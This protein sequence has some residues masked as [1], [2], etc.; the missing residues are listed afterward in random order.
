M[1]IKNKRG[2]TLVA[3]VITIVILLILAGIIITQLTERGL[4]EKTEEA[5]ERSINA[6]EKE[7]KTLEEYSDRINEIVGSRE[8]I[9]VDKSEYEE[10]KNDIEE[11]KK[12]TKEEKYS[13]TENV[14]G[15]WIDGKKIYRKVL[16][17]FSVT[18]ISNQWVDVLDVSK[19]NIENL[20][21]FK[22]YAK[23]DSSF[24]MASNAIANIASQIGD[25]NYLQLFGNVE[26][27]NID[28]IIIEYTK[29][30]N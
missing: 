8:Q 16:K 3:L 23:K 11:L 26:W 15:E 24:H 21:D 25:N 29:T 28:T 6:Q 2:I 17:G 7:N 12:Q 4:F 1:N 30:S 10:I 27:A 13:V 22:A 19:L 9:M 20:I 5:K 14:V 18:L